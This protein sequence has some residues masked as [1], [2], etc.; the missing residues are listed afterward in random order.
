MI[1]TLTK[2]V[3]PDTH[4]SVLESIKIWKIRGNFFDETECFNAFRSKPIAGRPIHFMNE[5]CWVGPLSSPPPPTTIIHSAL[6]SS[7]CLFIFYENCLLHF[8]FFFSPGKNVAHMMQNKT[9]RCIH[10]GGEA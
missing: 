1:S 2:V 7:S 8:F 10:E 5:A 6:Y 3:V 9:N 4:Q